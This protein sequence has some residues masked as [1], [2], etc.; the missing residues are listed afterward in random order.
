MILKYDVIV[1]GGGHAGCEAACA[2]ANMGAKTCLV[3]MDMNKIAQ[4]S[5][6]PAIGGI[7]KGQIVREIDALGGQM[8]LVTDATSIQFRMLNVGKG[9]AVWSPRA[10]CDR[11]KFI[12]EWRKHIDETENL[13]V[14]Q[15]QADELIVESVYVAQQQTKRAVGVRTIWG[16]EIYAKCVIV[17]AGTFQWTDAY[18]AQDGCRRSHS[19]TCRCQLHGKHHSS[20]YSIG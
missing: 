14:W 17:T 20:W 19:R 5:C 10:Q 3:T 8:G 18:R 13:D 6:N 12:W 7:A 2:S 16:T 15:D 1:I 11:G 9:P 4:M